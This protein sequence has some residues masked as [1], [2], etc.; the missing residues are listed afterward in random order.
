MKRIPYILTAAVLT[1]CLT[2]CGRSAPIAAVTTEAA[3][4]T[5]PIVTNTPVET[6]QA[7]EVPTEFT[8]P[9]LHS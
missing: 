2:G 5:V 9:E 4:E 6:T 8:I 7:A 1:L 3:S